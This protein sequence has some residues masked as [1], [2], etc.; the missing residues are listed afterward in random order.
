M[1]AP[2]AE[3]V[4]PTPQIVRA[5]EEDA[6]SPVDQQSTVSENER[7]SGADSR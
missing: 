3:S 5:G 4:L 7:G 1:Q 2:M 6:D